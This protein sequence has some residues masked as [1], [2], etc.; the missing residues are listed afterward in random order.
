MINT[1]IV[2][3]EYLLRKGLIA[4]IDWQTL[5]FQVVGEASD[6][7]EAADFI[8]N[9]PV[10]LVISDIRMPILSGIDLMR[11]VRERKKDVK[12][13]ILSG[14]DDFSYAQSALKYGAVSYVL[15]PFEEEEMVAEL[16][17]VK[18]DMERISRA[19]KERTE[20]ET[21]ALNAFLL[22]LVS[23]KVDKELFESNSSKLPINFPCEEYQVMV[24]ELNLKSVLNSPEAEAFI[25]T[26]IRVFKANYQGEALFQT[27]ECNKSLCEIIY[28]LNGRTCI[29]SA[30]EMIRN[31]Q[32]LLN[33]SEITK[34]NIGVGLEVAG[35]DKVSQSYRDAKEA[36]DFKISFGNKSVIYYK[37]IQESKRSPFHYPLD[38]ELKIFEALQ[39]KTQQKLEIY[40]N[41]FFEH[42]KSSASNIK[43][44]RQSAIQLISS[45]KHQNGI[46]DND[47]ELCEMITGF[48]DV[49]E[50]KEYLTHIFMSYLSEKAAE[51]GKKGKKLIDDV[52]EYVS[53][54]YSERITL[55]EISRIF[56]I[57]RSYFCRVFKEYTGINFYNYLNDFRIE[58]AKFLLKNSYYK[59]Y[60]ICEMI[61]FENSSYF[62]QLFKKVT[63]MT[64][65]EYRDA[66]CVPLTF[67]G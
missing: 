20:L 37:N 5:G 41:D 6:G 16:M 53:I 9:N 43:T 11:S 66:D 12:F 33:D 57:S 4:L 45:Y 25:K 64:P 18:N 55:E 65:C 59:N 60:E 13:I 47:L 39:L 23:N 56:F 24:L 17:K 67:A 49:D 3:D 38:L 32:T 28:M 62:N 26:L 21:A 54:H 8:E 19:E 40:I 10:D 50:I 46:E 44:I 22:A 30:N 63:G 27:S 34:Y 48:D 1:L 2:D 42:I 35:F 52:K 29:D 15:K 31:L 51:S 7:S 36:L 61:G 14:Y 58:K